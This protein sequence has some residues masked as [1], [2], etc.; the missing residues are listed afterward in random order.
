MPKEERREENKHLNKSSKI[1]TGNNNIN[2]L[3]L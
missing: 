1:P 3:G 2:F